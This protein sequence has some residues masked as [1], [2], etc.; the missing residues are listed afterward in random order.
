MVLKSLAPISSILP[1]YWGSACVQAVKQGGQ[2]AR[3]TEAE[4]AI[5]NPE[6]AGWYYTSTMIVD[7]TLVYGA[8]YY[9]S[10][11]V[12]D[13][14]KTYVS[15]NALVGDIMELASMAGAYKLAQWPAMVV[16][17]AVVTPVFYCAFG[18]DRE[19]IRKVREIYL[20]YGG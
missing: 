15:Q 11:V 19:T 2:I 5:P 8:S 18:W 20:L 9:G 7:L 1:I 16:A 10:T 4:R 17:T 6:T 3:H 12:R 14:F 13:L